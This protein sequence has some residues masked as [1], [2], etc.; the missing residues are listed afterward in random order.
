MILR[1]LYDYYDSLNDYQENYLA[2]I[3]FEDREIGFVIVIDGDGN[4]LDIEDFNNSEGGAQEFRVVQYIERTSNA[5]EIACVFWDTPEYVINLLGKTITDEPQ[6]KT[7]T[8]A[9]K[10][11]SLCGLYPN[12]REFRAVSSFYKKREYRNPKI[13]KSNSFKRISSSETIVRQMSFRLEGR[14]NIVAEHNDLYDYVKKQYESSKHIGTCFI[15]GKTGMPLANNSSVVKIFDS[16]ATSKLLSY[17]FNS[18]N[19]YGRKDIEN[20]PI[21]VEA[22]S[23]IYNAFRYLLR[24]YSGSK[25]LYSPLVSANRRKHRSNSLLVNRTMLFW[26]SS[27]S[28]EAKQI[29]ELT[30]DA[31]DNRDNPDLKTEKVKSLFNDIL[32]GQIPSISEDKF[33]MLGLAP[34]SARIAVVFWRECSLKDFAEAIKCHFT[35]TDIIDFRNKERKG[36][37]YQGVYTILGTIAKDG[38][39]SDL[40]P[41][42]VET[43]IKSI[44][45]KAPYPETLYQMCLGRVKSERKITITRAA[46]I[47][48][49]LNRKYE[50]LSNN[51][52]FITPMLN[53][54]ENN[55]GYLCGRLFAVYEY[56]QEKSLKDEGGKSTLK[57][58]FFSS[59][60]TRPQATFI[61]LVKLSNYYFTKISDKSSLVIK[62]RKTENEIIDKM[63]STGFP[64][65]LGNDDQGR[66]I[67]GYYHQR[68]SFEY[69]S[70]TTIDNVVANNNEETINV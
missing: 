13:A 8:F 23:K 38:R 6:V 49:Y 39:V 15:T 1:A 26:T 28:D 30:W 60:M 65:T 54:E 62:L 4:F 29:E 3:G 9:A 16:A 37:F 70:Q 27:N 12:N 43:L 33:F 18:A 25:Q 69:K 17:N 21:S 57:N 19:S 20:F 55:P 24:R 66:F 64:L 63:E 68:G 46:I 44:L 47:K 36:S 41:R 2:P 11:D 14:D 48:G 45:Q 31:I 32:S 35:D 59:A 5:S 52:K 61:E 22:D 34:N 40:P 7:R 58:R 10:V 50:H 51:Y 53:K 56:A 42:L 67:I